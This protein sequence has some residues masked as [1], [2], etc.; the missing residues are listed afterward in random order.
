MT[1]RLQSF[2]TT[3]ASRI[4][5]SSI[6]IDASCIPPYPSRLVYIITPGTLVR[7]VPDLEGALCSL[8]ASLRAALAAFPKSNHYATTYSLV[9]IAIVLDCYNPG[10]DIEVHVFRLRQRD[11]TIVGCP[12][13]ALTP[14]IT[15]Q[16]R[17]IE[18]HQ[19]NIQTPFTC[20]EDWRGFGPKDHPIFEAMAK[21][22]TSTK[23]WR[24]FKNDV[25]G[26]PPSPLTRC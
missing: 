20:A 9:N 23:T 2:T 14:R 16:I 12:D 18:R 3:I 10:E 22:S 24:N 1:P 6:E 5:A 13:P 26:L 7:L 25:S 17:D 11:N 8:I 15:Q 21:A 19:P 4:M